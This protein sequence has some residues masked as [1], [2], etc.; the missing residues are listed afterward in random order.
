MYFYDSSFIILIP[1][2]II[3]AWAQFKVSS[4]FGK[5]SKVSSINGYTGAEAARM[6]LDYNGLNNVP[7]ELIDGR[8]TDHYDPGKR[9]MRLSKD[10]F[11]GSSVASIGVAA[12]ETGHAVQHKNHYALLKSEIP[13][14][15]L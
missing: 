9:V 1:A 14:Y 5:Y 11:Y 4:T 8:L 13:L 3:A 15:L 7:I 2:I 12:H 6:L 10:I